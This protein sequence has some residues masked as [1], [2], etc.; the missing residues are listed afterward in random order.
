MSEFRELTL[1][2]SA[3]SKITVNF[4]LVASFRPSEPDEKGTT[5]WEAG[6]TEGF[7]VTESYEEVSRLAKGARV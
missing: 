2:G 6:N 3:P 4:A 1:A 7:D 5:I